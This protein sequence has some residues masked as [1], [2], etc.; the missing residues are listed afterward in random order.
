MNEP[1]VDCDDIGRGIKEAVPG[2]LALR[3]REL[4]I[5]EHLGEIRQGTALLVAV[6]ERDEIKR[7]DPDQQRDREHGQA[8]EDFGTDA[9][10]GR[11]AR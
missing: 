6:C 11:F 3:C 2:A 7:A 1:V 10:D 8:A 4:L 9:C 5:T